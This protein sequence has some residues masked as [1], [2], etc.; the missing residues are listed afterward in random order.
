MYDVS[1]ECQTSECKLLE[2]KYISV[3]Y[4]VFETQLIQ[5]SFCITPL[6]AHIL[7]RVVLSHL[8]VDLLS[9]SYLGK[10]QG[11]REPN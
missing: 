8:M 1:D 10:P 2:S 7:F 5:L 9:E 3:E 4:A 6:V 11:K